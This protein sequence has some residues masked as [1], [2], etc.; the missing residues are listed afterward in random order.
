MKFIKVSCAS[1]HEKAQTINTSQFPGLVFTKGDRYVI[2]PTGINFFIPCYVNRASGKT[3]YVKTDSWPYV[4]KRA[5][6]G[7]G[8]QRSLKIDY[9]A[10]EVKGK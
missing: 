4:L 8:N 10:K 7:K 5:L 3:L 6:V 1:N 2:K 9:I